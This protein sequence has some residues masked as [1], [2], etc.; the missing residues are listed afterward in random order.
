MTLVWL[1]KRT[2]P[3]LTFLCFYYKLLNTV[4]H[5]VMDGQHA[6]EAVP[7][8]VLSGGETLY[9]NVL[10]LV[11]IVGGRAHMQNLLLP[12]KWWSQENKSSTDISRFVRGIL[13]SLATCCQSRYL[14]QNDFDNVFLLFCA[15]IWIFLW[16]YSLS[17]ISVSK[18][19]QNWHVQKPFPLKMSYSGCS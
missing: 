13:S 17:S 10:K 8:Y 1:K 2:C 6:K 7:H 18:H 15:A 9:Q 14:S 11:Y 4:W 19:L 3:R 16:P 12:L 5:E